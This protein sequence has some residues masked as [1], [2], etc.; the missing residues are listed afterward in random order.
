[1]MCWENL[2]DSLEEEPNKEMSGEDEKLDDD[3]EKQN[4][5]EAQEEH[6]KCT[7]N[8]GNQLKLSFEEF[9]SGMEDDASMLATQEISLKKS[10]YIT[11]LKKQAKGTPN[12]SHNYGTK[13]NEEE[14]PEDKSLQQRIGLLKDPPPKT[15]TMIWKITKNLVVR[16][17]K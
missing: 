7:V 16:K 13:V 2:E 8:T 14:G 11:N 4:Y 12:D 3:K 1:M 17:T 6:T 10:V 5:E 15:L 9:N